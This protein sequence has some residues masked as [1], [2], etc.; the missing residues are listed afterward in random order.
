MCG[1]SY[2]DGHCKLKKRCLCDWKTTGDMYPHYPYAP[3]YHGYY[4][5]RPY[6]YTN[7]LRQKGEIIALGGNPKAPYAHKMF[8]R[9]YE[10]IDLTTYEEAPADGDGVP[11][12]ERIHNE[13]PS[14]EDILKSK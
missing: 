14:L 13:L 4:Y 6:N 3:A 7:I 12:L 2:C 10:Q 9:I 1:S 5:F 8:D 11:G